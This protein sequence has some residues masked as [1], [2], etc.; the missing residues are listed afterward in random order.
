MGVTI[1]QKVK[2][3][4]KPWWI[5]ISHQGKRKSVQIGDK[6]AAESAASS[7]RQELA[8]GQ[9]NINEQKEIPVFGE[10]S[11]KWLAYIKTM[12]RESTHERY[13]QV[14][15]QHVLPVFNT[16]AL[17]NITRGDVRNSMLLKIEEG[18][19]RS[20]ICVYRDVMSGVF[21]FAID[22]EIVSSNPVA[23]ITKRLE[24]KREKKDVE[25]LTSEE[26][27]LFLAVCESLVP[28]YYAFFLMA[29]RTG[30]RLGEVLAV[31]WSD[32]DFNSSFIWVRRSYRRGQFTRP[33]NGKSRKVDM[34][35]QLS[36]TLKKLETK[37]RKE[38]LKKGLKEMPELVFN[39]HSRVIEQNYM[40]RVFKRVLKKAG[41]R[42]IKLHGLRHTFASL[43]LS[44]GE[45]PVYVKEQLG[46]SSIQIT[47]DI[48][49][50]WIQSQ[51]NK[52]VNI[53]DTPA[54]TCTLYAPTD[55]KAD[56][57]N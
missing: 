5:F 23:G 32:I 50:H 18:F 57:S 16:M 49:G 14:L 6:R 15:N 43:L 25:P 17:D 26:L 29:A 28:E 42:I 44:Q 55:R 37:K 13:E 2:G 30:M 40:R 24:L 35:P 34:S 11:K 47:V 53:L 21:N 7:I 33:K 31:R 27:V 22:E 9:L 19:S 46:H 4:G 45:S 8:K 38:I 48:Y 36:T 10:Y 56:V 20:S 51:K 1:R 54:P 52:G 3:K 39:R 41:I 12:R